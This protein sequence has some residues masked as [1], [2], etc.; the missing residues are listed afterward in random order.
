ML[1]GRMS[2]AD[3]ARVLRDLTLR[4]VSA[5][6]LAD[7]ARSMRSHVVRVPVHE[8]AIDT[9]GTGGSGLDRINTSTLAAFILAAEGVKV[10]KHGN[11]AASGRCGSFDVL[12]AVGCRIDLGPESVGRTLDELGIGFMFARLY[13]PAMAYVAGVRKSLGIRTVFNLLGPLTN[14]AFVRRQVLGVSEERTGELMAKVLRLLGHERATVVCGSDGLDEVTLTGPTVVFFLHEER[15]DRLVVHPEDMGLEEVEFGALA[16]GG[17][18]QNAH[19]FLRILKGEETGPKRDL[20]LANAAAGFFVVNR[21]D[22][23]KDGVALAR[24]SIESGRAYDFFERY[25]ALT[26]AL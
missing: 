7:M 20:V 11:K 10:A 26:Q 24:E 25:R 23:I 22:C 8:D 21:F 2:E 4:D 15:I 5:A 13:H 3:M 16:G 1:A 19:D 9:C 14:P 18:E 6:A 12:E 17:I